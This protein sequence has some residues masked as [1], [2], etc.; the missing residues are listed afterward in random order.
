MVQSHSRNERT[1]Q[2]FF[3]PALEMPETAVDGFD[4]FSDLFTDE[5]DFSSHSGGSG[6]HS[7]APNESEDKPEQGIKNDR[8]HDD[9]LDMD[10]SDTDIAFRFDGQGEGPSTDITQIGISEA[11]GEDIIPHTV[12]N[13]RATTP[14]G[15]TDFFLTHTSTDNLEGAHPFNP[16][17]RWSRIF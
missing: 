6:I 5:D 2:I 3:L 17:R 13:G 4:F 1:I 8:W 7:S 9:V 16:L 14:A 15:Y 11:L 12:A 10:D